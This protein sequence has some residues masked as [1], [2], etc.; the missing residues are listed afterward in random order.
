MQVDF[1]EK[2]SVR[3]VAQSK[4]QRCMSKMEKPNAIISD[5]Q[6]AIRNSLFLVA[7]TIYGRPDSDK[8]DFEN[9]KE[10]AKLFHLEDDFGNLQTA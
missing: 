1:G 5:M 8:N 3:H 2:F 9:L 10:I 6:D 7:N 4:N